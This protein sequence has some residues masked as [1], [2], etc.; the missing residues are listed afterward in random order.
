MDLDISSAILSDKAHIKEI[1]KQCFGDSDE[2]I[3]FFLENVFECENALV[4]RDSGIPISV[5]HIL[6]ID[7]KIKSDSISAGYIYAAATLPQYQGMGLMKKL[8]L[9]AEEIAVE[10]G[11][12]VLILVPAS[13]SLFLFYEKAGYKSVVDVFA[14]DNK[15]HKKINNNVTIED[16]DFEDFYKIR[17]QSFK[18]EDVFFKWNEKLLRYIYSRAFFT[19]KI[20]KKFKYKKIS[21]MLYF[22]PRIM[23]LKLRSLQAI[24]KA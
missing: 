10:R 9:S 2:Y 5:L 13:E 8:L 20:I 16:C 3:D 7:L 15:K 11:I 12:K 21:D 23:F 22:T 19:N 4:I 18:N 14:Y 6:P 24:K 17:S 1:W